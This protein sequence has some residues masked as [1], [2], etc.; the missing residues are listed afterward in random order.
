MFDT[1]GDL[2]Y[3]K[4]YAYD[5]NSS[6]LN[7]SLYYVKRGFGTYKAA[8]SFIFTQAIEGVNS[9]IASGNLGFITNLSSG[10]YGSFLLFQNP[11][12]IISNLDDIGLSSGLESV[13]NR[14]QKGKNHEE[15][16]LVVVPNEDKSKDVLRLY[17]PSGKDKQLK[18]LR[19]DQKKFVID[20]V[21]D[22]LYSFKNKV[23]TIEQL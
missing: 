18:H 7:E 9:T 17:I 14:I 2:L 1:T 19:E 16:I 21:E 5:E 23:V 10:I 20:Q 13:F 15:S 8:R 22:I 4:Q 6:L 3:K 11:T 12:E